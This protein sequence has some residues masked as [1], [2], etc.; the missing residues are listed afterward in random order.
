MCVCVCDRRD[1]HHA[2]K[3]CLKTKT[4]R[5][6]FYE[7]NIINSRAILGSSFSVVYDDFC[8]H[9]QNIKH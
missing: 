7:G 5:E 6:A 3:C 9:A 4:V 8:L 1:S 2:T